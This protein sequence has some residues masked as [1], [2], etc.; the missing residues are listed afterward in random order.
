MKLLQLKTL[1][2]LFLFYRSYWI[3]SNA[4]TA[5]C[6]YLFSKYGLSIFQALFWFKLVTLGIVYYYVNDLKKKEY[7]YYQNLGVSKSLLWI[8][9]LSFDF[10]FFL[11]L[12][13][14]TYRFR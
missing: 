5:T 4:I 6:L 3:T 11:F 12:I 13:I 14:Q 8:V 9:T 10:L 7:F 2:L 1:R